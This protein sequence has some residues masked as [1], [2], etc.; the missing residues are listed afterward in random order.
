MAIIFPVKTHLVK[1][2]DV[3]IHEIRQ[4]WVIAARY[5]FS[6]YDCLI[7]A[8]AIAS[9]CSTRYSEDLQHG[10]VIDSQLTICNPFLDAVQK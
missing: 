2:G 4:A 3:G 9:G 7:I 5:G 8:A 10:Q 6:H 1:L